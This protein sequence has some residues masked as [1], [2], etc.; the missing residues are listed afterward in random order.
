MCSC[1]RIVV[2]EHAHEHADDAALLASLQG[3]QIAGA[4]IDVY[5]REPRDL[6]RPFFR[7]DNVILGSHN[8][9]FTDEMP[10]WDF[11]SKVGWTRLTA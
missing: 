6:A 11:K 10:P 3:G 8:L 1:E 2:A 5:Q 4:G 9:A 7:L